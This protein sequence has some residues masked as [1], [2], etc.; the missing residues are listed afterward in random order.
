MVNSKMVNQEN[1]KILGIYDKWIYGDVMHDAF[2]KNMALFGIDIDVREDIDLT[3]ISEIKENYAAVLLGLLIPYNNV[4][5]TSEI[6]S[7]D[8]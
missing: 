4:E 6:E 1:I 8:P 2:P 5:P 7:C 3:K